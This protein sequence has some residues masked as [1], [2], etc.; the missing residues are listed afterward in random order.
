MAKISFS[1]QEKS[2]ESVLNWYEDQKEALRDLRAKIVDA[3]I[4]SK[5]IKVDDKF[6]GLTLSEINEY[7][8]NNEAELEHLACFDTI[9]ATEAL[10]RVDY[11]KK[12]YNK[13]KS[14]LGRIFRDVYKKKG[15]R[16]SLE[17]DIIENWKKTSGNEVFSNFLGLLNYRHWLAHGRYWNPKFGRNYSFDTA[18]EIS[19][20]IFDAV[21]N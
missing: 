6:I 21:L 8:I 1:G 3:I 9:S 10:L 11:Y 18:F 2:I 19:E 14:A 17:E 16:I 20:T 15:N 7:F 12:V 5:S 4:N 13:D